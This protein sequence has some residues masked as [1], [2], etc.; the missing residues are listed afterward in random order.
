MSSSF[1]KIKIKDDKLKVSKMQFLGNASNTCSGEGAEHSRS[2]S[3]ASSLG[4]GY[5]PITVD[6]LIERQSLSPD[7]PQGHEVKVKVS[8]RSNNT[9]ARGER[10][11][12]Q[13]QDIL[14][15]HTSGPGA[16]SA[17]DP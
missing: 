6:G 13:A 3:S 10:Q 4:S 2:K 11:V 8:D 15:R 5:K 17:L 12:V 16:P 14:Q 9:F 1:F 7:R